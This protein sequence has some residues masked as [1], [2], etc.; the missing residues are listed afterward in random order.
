M[1]FL[2]NQACQV[3]L[4]NDDMSTKQRIDDL[5]NSAG[6]PP[7]Q[8]KRE[9]ANICGIT[10][11]AV[12]RWYS[13]DTA[14]I[15]AENLARI[16]KHF[17]VSIDW[18]ATGRESATRH[19][20]LA[21]DDKSASTVPIYKT[22]DA[23]IESDEQPSRWIELGSLGELSDFSGMVW[24]YIE[25]SEGMLPRIK[26]GELVIVRGDPARIVSGHTYLIRIDG[27]AILAYVKKVPGGY[28]ASFE[29]NQSGWHERSIEQS[30]ILAE[31]VFFF[32]SQVF[33]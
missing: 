25:Q 6:I 11:E 32:P 1:Y 17:R 19:P 13:G 30:S 15:D 4:Y 22:P 9:L 33:R 26:P 29:S 5:L 8:R 12:R 14:S 27:E 7:R 23:P 21:E 31:L 10:Y 16:A 28:I 20:A 3:G 2:Y 18:L 24:G